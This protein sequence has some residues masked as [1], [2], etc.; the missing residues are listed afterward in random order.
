[1][2]QNVRFE[3][4]TKEDESAFAPSLEDARAR[5][6]PLFPR[7]MATFGPQ[8]VFLADGIRVDAGFAAPIGPLRVMMELDVDGRPPP[9]HPALAIL[10]AMLGAGWIVDQ[11][12]GNDRKRF[13]DGEP[14]TFEQARA[15]N[16]LERLLSV[17]IEAPWDELRDA[18]GPA[19]GVPTML[20]CAFSDDPRLSRFGWDDLSNRIL[21]QGTVYSA[22]APALDWMLSR[23]EAT[24]DTRTRGRVLYFVRTCLDGEYEARPIDDD[25]DHLSR[26]G[27]GVR[28]VVRERGAGL[29][30]MAEED[31]ELRGLA[32]SIAARIPKLWSAHDWP[33]LL[34]TCS[35]ADRATAWYVRA[36]DQP[37]DV[38]ALR[39]A[40]AHGEPEE[41]YA[42]S[43]LL[44]EAGAMDAAG[45]ARM[46]ALAADERVADWLKRDFGVYDPELHADDEIA[47]GTPS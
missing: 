18:F 46:R 8:R 37:P 2:T 16:L 21:H 14:A 33:K 10:G 36:H 34:E 12:R 30:R 17:V 47:R 39:A 22:T 4:R 3:V 40:S 44:C 19:T 45:A 11:V 15:L 42:A 25:D 5:L 9:G 23:A 1:M 29:F 27:Q 13:T 41:R 28:R 24:T 26:A 7:F 20:A 38:P 31:A 35:G 6:A 32:L 43:W